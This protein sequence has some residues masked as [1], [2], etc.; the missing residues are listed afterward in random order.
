MAQKSINIVISAPEEHFDGWA[1]V[2]ATAKGW[3]KVILNED[4]R[5]IENPENAIAYSEKF[6][7]LYIWDAVKEQLAESAAGEARQQ[8]KKAADKLLNDA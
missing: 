4:G 1:E 8:V 2:F 7:K 3:K 5:P 6:I